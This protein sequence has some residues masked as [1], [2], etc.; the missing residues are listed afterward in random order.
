MQTSIRPIIF[1][2]ISIST[3]SCGILWQDT[4]VTISGGT[5]P[6]FIVSGTGTLGALIIYGPKQRDVNS[7][8]S[9]ALWEIQPVKGFMNGERLSKIE[10][11]EYGVVPDGYSQIYPEDAKP[12]PQLKAGERYE[13]WFRT[14]SA[15]EARAYFE[16]RDGLAIVVGN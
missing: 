6:V 11:V 2:I 4:S 15:K 13:Y 10:K 7:D 8:R 1:S 9:Y 14:V 16:I 5:K 3:I 12:A